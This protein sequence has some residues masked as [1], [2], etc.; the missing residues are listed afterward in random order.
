MSEG[1]NKLTI[2]KYGRND[3]SDSFQYLKFGEVVFLEDPLGLD[4]VKVW[5]KGSVATGGDDE[6]VVQNSVTIEEKYSNLPWCLPLMPKH[7][8]VKPKIGE[9]VLIFLINKQ[10]EASDRLYIGPIISQ[11][12]KLNFDSART[13]ALAGFTFGPV[14]PN[15]NISNIPDLKGVFPSPND[16]SIQGRYNTDITQKENEIVI[17]AGKFKPTEITDLNPY[18]IKFNAQTQGFIQI[19]NNVTLPKITETEVSERLGT[20][21]NIV[22]NKINLI[23]HG[24][25]PNFNVT[26]Q[27]DLISGD[28]MESILKTA[29][30]IPFGDVLLEYLILLKEAFLAHVHNGNGRTPTDLTIDGNK[31]SVAA[32]KEKAAKLEQSMLSQNIRIN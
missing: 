11:L 9:M 16:V 25:S 12:D 17:R 20:V 6:L 27:I 15:V 26:N 14:I 10:K 24:G 19:K 18:P 21:T 7:I 28:V 5:I 8:T 1:T 13:T 4:R 22:S 32:F 23:T 3:S 2:G 31:Q 30:Q 29:H